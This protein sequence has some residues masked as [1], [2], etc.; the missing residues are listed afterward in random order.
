M[1]V[2]LIDD[3]PV[4]S[5]SGLSKCQEIKLQESMARILDS[6]QN[7]YSDLQMSK[8]SVALIARKV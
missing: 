4:Q 1:I 6:S 3:V 7:K 8:Y 2:M 5:T